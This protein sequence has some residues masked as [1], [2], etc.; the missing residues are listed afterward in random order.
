[1]RLKT[2]IPEKFWPFVVFALHTGL[3]QAEQFGL[4]WE[5]VDFENKTITI[6]RF[7][8]GEA[9]RVPMN[10]SVIE[11]LLQEK[12]RS[13][14]GGFTQRTFR[15]AVEAAGVE[16]FTWHDLRHTFASRLVM[17]GVDLRTVQELLGHKSIAM[18]LRYAHLSPGHLAEA[19]QRLSLG[20][21]PPPS[22]PVRDPYFPSGTKTDT[23]SRP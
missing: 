3:R 2:A 18:T 12:S 8:N 11:L 20:S 4:R 23:A 10:Q 17:K 6:P 13:D 19:V 1:M 21:T 16:N 15:P 7:K 14:A 22:S 5:N 9:R